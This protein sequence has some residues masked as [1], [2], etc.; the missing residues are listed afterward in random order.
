LSF[1]RTQALIT[2]HTY[3][4]NPHTHAHTCGGGG[5]VRA[6]TEVVI[7]SLFL[8]E[9]SWESVQVSTITLKLEEQTECSKGQF[10]IHP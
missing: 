1:S 2:T 7:L 8:A 3:T 4:P 5:G 10:N 6:L 9:R